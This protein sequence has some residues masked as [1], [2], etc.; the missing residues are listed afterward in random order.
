MKKNA[1]ILGVGIALGIISAYTVSG[2]VVTLSVRAM[3]KAAEALEKAN[4]AHLFDLENQGD[5]EA[6]IEQ[7][8]PTEE[9]EAP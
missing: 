6:E 3:R 9:S 1:A 8:I 4:T 5:K 2:L 7:M